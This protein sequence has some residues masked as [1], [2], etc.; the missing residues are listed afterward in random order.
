MFVIVE[1]VDGLSSFKGRVGVLN[2]IGFVVD[3]FD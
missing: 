2:I 3:L 1:V